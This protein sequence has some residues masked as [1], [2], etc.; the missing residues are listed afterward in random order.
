MES[1]GVNW[2]LCALLASRDRRDSR[3]AMAAC[4]LELSM[5][6]MWLT[7]ETSSV[8]MHSLVICSN[9]ST[10]DST[11]SSTACAAKD[12]GAASPS[13]P[14]SEILISSLPANM[15]TPSLMAHNPRSHKGYDGSD[16]VPSTAIEHHPT[17]VHSRQNCRRK[18]EKRIDI[19]Y[20]LHRRQQTRC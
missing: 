19:T 16:S 6:D 1:D 8:L 14:S 5:D 12:G 9:S 20:L 10:V 18:G 4:L 2:E 7:E 11:V 3:S 13:P 15:E 17:P